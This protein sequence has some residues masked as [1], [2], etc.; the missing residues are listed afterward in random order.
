MSIESL[1]KPIVPEFIQCVLVAVSWRR[2]I[3]GRTKTPAIAPW[4]TP[5][6]YELVAASASRTAHFSII[7]SMAT[8]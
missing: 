6:I 7:P 4:I 2:D 8:W 5:T 3:D 1:R